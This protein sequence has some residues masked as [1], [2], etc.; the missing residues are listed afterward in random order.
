MDTKFIGTRITQLRLAKNVSER[1]MSLD[2]GYSSGYIQQVTAGKSQP[3]ITKFR[4]ICEYLEITP[5][6]FFFEGTPDLYALLSDAVKVLP[7]E[8]IVFLKRYLEL[9]LEA[10]KDALKEK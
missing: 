7:K 4:D 8:H 5:Y 2:L 10:V 3:S 6:E 1:K 9:F